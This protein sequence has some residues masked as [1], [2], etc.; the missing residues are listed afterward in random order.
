MELLQSEVIGELDR[1]LSESLERKLFGPRNLR[2]AVPAH[3]RAHQAK[4]TRQRRHPLVQPPR[5]AH[6]GM[7]QD[8]R[9]MWTPGIAKIIDGISELQSVTRGHIMHF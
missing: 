4:V 2:F 6:R 1:V 7:Y 3:V 9:F 8:E 5:A